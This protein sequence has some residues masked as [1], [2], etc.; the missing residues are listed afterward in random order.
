MIFISIH[1]DVLPKEMEGVRIIES[2]KGTKIG[3]LLTDSF[4]SERRMEKGDSALFRSGDEAHGIVNAYVLRD[5][6][7]FI[8]EK[9]LLELGNF[10]NP[11][12]VWRIRDYKVRENYAQLIT[13]ALIKLMK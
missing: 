5:D 8:K 9:V 6:K 13:R 3:K 1:F 10:S 2:A 12:D 4:S 11:K 7:N